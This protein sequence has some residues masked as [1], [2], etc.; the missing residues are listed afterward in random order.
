MFA[1]DVLT[2]LHIPPMWEEWIVPMATAVSPANNDNDNDNDAKTGTNT[3]AAALITAPPSTTTRGFFS[4]GPFRIGFVGTLGVLLALLF[5]AAMVN[6]SAAITLIFLAIFVSLGLF[7]V[8]RNLRARGAS[9]SGSILIV[10]GVFLGAVTALAVVVVPIVSAQ[11]A[12]LIRTLPANL[13]NV[14]TQPWFV[15]LNDSLGG[16]L[17]TLAEWVQRSTLDPAIWLAVSGGALRLGADIINGTFGLV[18]V[19][20]LTIYFV[21]SLDSMKTALYELV[22][23]SKRPGFIEIAEEIFESIGKYLGGQVILAAI[24]SVFTFVL[25]TILGVQ[26]A[27]ILAFIALF[28]TLIPVIGSVISTTIMTAVS[29]FNSPSTA[30]VVLIVMIVYMQ[31]ESYVISPRIVGKAISIPASLVLI[32]ALIGGTLLGLLGALVASPLAASVLLILKKVVVPRQRL[33]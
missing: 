14:Q 20:V 27:I 21:S 18:F 22:P 7:P 23:M 4:G 9:A 6:L 5:G 8:V 10:L 2:V 31:V 3:T 28:V 33:R 12:E 32:G 15:D 26:Y 24:N 19:V 16:H 17:T 1:H 11:A 13:R 30:L 25:L 29:L